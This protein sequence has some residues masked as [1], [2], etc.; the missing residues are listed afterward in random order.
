MKVLYF[1]KYSRK[2]ASSRLRSFQ[3]FPFLEKEN[4][5]VTVSPLFNDEYLTNLYLGKVSKWTVAKGYFQ[6]FYKLL[7]VRYYDRVF[8][9]YELFP[10]LPAWGEFFLKLLRVKYIVDYDD[11]I[12][13]NYDLSPNKIV[14]NLLGKKID[15]VMKYST[16]VIAGNNYLAERAKKAGANKICIMP[17]V[18]DIQRY[19]IKKRGNNDKIIIGWIGSPSTLKYIKIIDTA[20]QYL[21]EKYKVQINI[22]GAKAANDIGAI[23]NVEYINWQEDTEVTS[24]SNFDIGIMPLNDSPWEEGKCSYKLIQ[25]MAAGLPI[26]ASPV[27]MNKEVVT[28]GENG[29]LVN[30]E[31]EWIKALEQYILSGEKRVLHGLAGRAKVEEKYCVQ[32]THK[33]LLKILKEW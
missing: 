33:S 24:I 15:K 6:R 7:S 10:Y 21:V 18:I 32:V 25:Y 11:A 1:T 13:H 27:G 28:G 3:Y 23:K 8:I 19:K 31:E 22:V 26:V 30:T 20:L 14:R 16:C 12:F 4:V 2:G 5:Q 29:F 17:T 9:E